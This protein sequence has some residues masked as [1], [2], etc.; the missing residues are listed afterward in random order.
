MFT[1]VG[2][3]FK[4]CSYVHIAYSTITVVSFLSTFASAAPYASVTVDEDTEYANLSPVS[5][6][7]SLDTQ[8][9]DL[10][11][12]NVIYSKLSPGT[13]TA[14]GTRPNVMT[15]KQLSPTPMDSMQGV[16]SI[17]AEASGHIPMMMSTPLSDTITSSMQKSMKGFN[18]FIMQM[19]MSMPDVGQHQ[20]SPCAA[21]GMS[22]SFPPLTM[23]MA[24]GGDFMS[25]LR[26]LTE[27]LNPINLLNSIV[28]GIKS[29]SMSMQASMHP[30]TSGM[31]MMTSGCASND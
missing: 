18:D 17:V 27:T 11:G 12:S 7:H 6:S 8:S 4:S 20:S 26:Q 16:S 30:D 21:L 15:L 31:M 13:F 9:T 1:M 3:I 28:Q 19:S 22:S 10:T 25:L 14:S 2:C 29:T 5:T 23:S 24:S